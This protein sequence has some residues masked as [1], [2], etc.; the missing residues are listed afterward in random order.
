MRE[1]GEMIREIARIELEM[2]ALEGEIRKLKGKQTPEAKAKL[3]ELKEQLKKLRHKRGWLYIDLNRTYEIRNAI[4][5]I[6]ANVKR[7]VED[8]KAELRENRK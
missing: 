5:E 7:M 4:H 2:E 1:F 6:W 8:E 3:E